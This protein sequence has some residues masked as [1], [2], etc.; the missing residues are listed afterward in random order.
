M[1]IILFIIKE[2][3]N[4]LLFPLTDVIKVNSM[5][6]PFTVLIFYNFKQLTLC[7]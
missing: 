6:Y 4:K 5:Y 1:N 3:I 2:N 7:I